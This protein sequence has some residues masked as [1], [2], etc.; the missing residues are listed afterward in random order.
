MERLEAKQVKGH[1]YYY[2]SK[3]AGSTIAVDA[4]G[5]NTSANSRTSSWPFTG[6]GQR[7][8][9]RGLAVSTRPGWTFR[10][11]GCFRS[12]KTSAK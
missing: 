11:A 1:T 2:Y 3:W 4:S 9:A 12:W 8:F 6:V 10:C 7:L 5:R